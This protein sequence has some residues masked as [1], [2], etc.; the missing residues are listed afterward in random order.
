MEKNKEENKKIENKETKKENKENKKDIKYKWNLEDIYKDVPSYKNDLKE[1]K[2][3]GKEM[4]KYEGKLNNKKDILE[5]F[6]LSTKK[7]RIL[8]KLSAYVYLNSAIDMDNEEYKMLMSELQNV[9]V[10]ISED[11]IFDLSELKDLEDDVLREYMNDPD[12]KN[13]K[14]FFEKLI[15]EKK[16]IF[17]KDIE[18]I[19]DYASAG[20]EELYSMYNF[21]TELEIPFKDAVDKDGK[22]Y[23]VT[24]SMYGSYLESK[25]E[26][27][28]K[29]AMLSRLEGYKNFNNSL[30]SAYIGNLKNITKML[31]CRKYESKLDEKLKGL[32]LSKEVY[33]NLVNGVEENL[34]TVK[35]YK[36]LVYKIY[37]K[38]GLVEEGKRIKPWDSSLKPFEEK[39][40]YIPYEDAKGTVIDGL[41]VLGE[42]YL[43]SL[44]H[45]LENRYIDVFPRKGKESGGFN[46]D[47]YDA[48]PYILLN[49]EGTHDD[50]TTIAHE[51]G[52][53]MHGIYAKKQD[54]ELHDYSTIIAETASTTNEVIMANYLIENEKD[55]VKKAQMLLNFIDTIFATLVTQTMFSRFEEKAFKLAEDEEILTPNILNEIYLDLEK[56]YI[57]KIY[58]EKDKINETKEEKEDI[59]KIKNLRKYSWTRVPHFYRPFYVFSYSIGITAAIN[60][61]LKISEDKKY[62]DKYINM[63]KSGGSEKIMDTFKIAEIDLEDKN[64]YKN[65]FKFVNEKIDELE[66]IVNEI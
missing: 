2:R 23:P 43:E 66:K 40:I 12:F 36:K 11:T 50:V 39:Q 47:I 37:K 54:Y 27:L 6:N 31:K 57:P 1:L 5:Y 53:A 55:K 15:E 3:L 41:S 35:R 62:L 58:T 26:V 17:S 45:I 20:I 13:F 9:V 4:A 44:K 16:H 61:Y 18:Q 25:D 14:Y 65:A 19:I 32:D 49:Y 56:K 52:H 48:H 51:L 28:R 29:T 63:L 8:D 42:G 7:S 10:K 34:D 38:M 33:L 21:L 60:I 30:A 22:T 24:N 46:L 64:I 59:D